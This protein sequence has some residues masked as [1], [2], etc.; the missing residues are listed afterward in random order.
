MTTCCCC[1]KQ[2]EEGTGEPVIVND[3]KKPS[4]LILENFVQNAAKN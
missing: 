4:D 1:G 3:K 2:F